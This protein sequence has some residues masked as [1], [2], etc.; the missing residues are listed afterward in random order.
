MEIG[1]DGPGALGGTPGGVSILGAAG[2][3]S[4]A[5]T[6][7]ATA[8]GAP[9]LGAEVAGVT[10][11]GAS[12]GD[13]GGAGEGSLSAGG[14][15]GAG[16]PTEGEGPGAEGAGDGGSGG[17]AG[18]A[19]G[20]GLYPNCSSKYSAVILSSVL[21]ATRAAAMPSSFALARTTLLSTPTFFAMS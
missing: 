6:G 2:D 5:I 20:V 3:T 14:A 17:G 1:S 16:A 8:G 12:G 4:V 9:G 10:G 15:G 13:S 7:G 21:D 18:G 11:S 19:G